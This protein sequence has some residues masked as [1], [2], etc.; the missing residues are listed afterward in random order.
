M[1][2]DSD[3]VEIEVSPEAD[4]LS[5]TLRVADVIRHRDLDFVSKPG[6]L[7]D[8]SLKLAP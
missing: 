7:V 8:P 4:G 1:K 2:P 6:E 5:R 3:I